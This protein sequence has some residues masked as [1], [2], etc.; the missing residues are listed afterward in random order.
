[1]AAQPDSAGTSSK[2]QTMSSL[3][4]VSR[5]SVLAVLLLALG[6]STHPLTV[7]HADTSPCDQVQDDPGDPGPGGEPD[8]GGTVTNA[9][10]LG[11]ISGATMQLY[12]CDL[13]VGS[14]VTSVVTNSSGHYEFGSLAQAYY[15][16]EAAMTGP[17]S[18]KSP[19]SGT[20]NPSAAIANG[21]GDLGVDLSFQ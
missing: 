8:I 12:R 16:V 15:Y 11:P 14:Y 20:S 5:F 17:L 10:S 7:A 19:A 1:V 13:G 9:S 4:S 6:F 21:D 2:E 18:G 3:T